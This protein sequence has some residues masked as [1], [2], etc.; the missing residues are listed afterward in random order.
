[1]SHESLI[2]PGVGT[3]DAE[4]LRRAYA[5]ESK[6]DGEQLYRD[7]AATY[8]QTMIDGLGYQVPKRT[9]EVFAAGVTWRRDKVLDIGCGTGLVG[10]ELVRHGFHFFDG[11]DLSTEMMAEADQREIYENFIVAD[12]NAPLPL[13]DDSY[14]GA[15]CAGTFTSGHVGPGC[16]D[17]IFRVLAP[18]GFLACSIHNS[19]WHSA[20]F[21]PAFERLADTGVAKVL[22]NREHPF[23]TTSTGV[24]GRFCLLQRVE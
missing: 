14:S 19:V 12:L 18:G 22:E 9:A 7:W 2:P 10:A 20:G 4:L 11:L 21:A 13:A 3:G 5:L 15:V 8:D 6:A 1:M 23:Y 16:L 24:D 17:E